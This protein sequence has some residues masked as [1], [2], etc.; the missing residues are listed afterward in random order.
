MTKIV[1]NSLIYFVTLPKLFDMKIGRFSVLFLVFVLLLTNCRSRYDNFSELPNETLLKGVINDSVTFYLVKNEMPDGSSGYYFLDIGMSAAITHPF[2]AY[3]SGHMVLSFDDSVMV[4]GVIKNKGIKDY[5]YKTTSSDIGT[6]H[7]KVIDISQDDFEFRE[8]FIDPIVDSTTVIENILY[9]KADGYYTTHDISHIP[10]GENSGIA[11]EIRRVHRDSV[12]QNGS[13]ELDLLLD[14]HYPDD[15]SGQKLPLVVYLHGG[16]FLFG[17]KQNELQEIFTEELVRRGYILASVN[18]RLG[19]SITGFGEVERA[20]Y[21]GVQDTRAALRYLVANA[22]KYRINTDH[23]YLCG[24]SAGA[25]IALTTAFMDQDNI[26]RSAGKRLFK[27]D[28]GGL[29]ESGNE[30]ESEFNIA[31]I[32]GMWGALIDLSIID[33]NPDTP[34][35]LFHGSDD[36]IVRPD[37]GLPFRNEVNGFFHNILESAW[38]MHG[39]ESIYKYMTEKEM[40]AEYVSFK[41]YG[42]EPHLDPDGSL[43]DNCRVIREKTR[44]YLYKYVA[45]SL[46]FTIEGRDTIKLSDA[47]PSSYRVYPDYYQNMRWKVQGGTIVKISDNNIIDI[48]WHPRAGEHSIEAYILDSYG[49]GIRKS[50]QIIISH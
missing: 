13:K 6:I 5:I 45:S 18:Y 21:R 19:L 37:S 10:K 32:I 33:N 38:I 42:H 46:P 3:P 43:N 20:I 35:L 9:G 17:D 25:I 30:I 44:E 39:S 7:L 49:I 26:F 14:L 15:G 31:G 24:S 28:L 29:D 27:P 22:E 12:R 36:D 8:R 1:E 41:G 47:I 34:T 11:E 48:V 23:I 40:P 16:A 50:K 2:T 4:E